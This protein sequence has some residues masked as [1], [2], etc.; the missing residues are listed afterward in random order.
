MPREKRSF[1]LAQERATDALLVL[2]GEGGGSDEVAPLAEHF[3]RNGFTV[4]ASSL[5]F[6]ALGEPGHSPLYWQTCVD[7]AENRYD[8]LQHYS[9]RAVVLGVGLGATIA[10]HLASRRRVSAVLALFPTLHAAPSWREHLVAALR[11]LTP[12]RAKS[13]AG[14]SQQRELAASG[15][16]ETAGKVEVPLYVLAEDPRDRSD[17]GRSAQVAR[18]LVSRAATQVR[19]VRPEEVRP[20]SELPQPL[21]EELLTFARS[22]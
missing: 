3:H 19:L 7:E 15:A 2:P 9:T 13:V 16:L 21:L 11:R 12:W 10:I 17:V 4:L 20:I 14:W 8:I 5:S 22:R 1:L 18:Q 6:R